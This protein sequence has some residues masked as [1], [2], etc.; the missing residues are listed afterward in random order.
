MSRAHPHGIVVCA[1]LPDAHKI[2]LTLTQ[3]L[4]N[5][6]TQ[7][8]TLTV[9]GAIFDKSLLF[10]NRF[11]DFTAAPT[12]AIL[13]DFLTSLIEPP[14][15]LFL[16]L[17]VPSHNNELVVPLLDCFAMAANLSLLITSSHKPLCFHCERSVLIYWRCEMC[18]GGRF[19]LCTECKTLGRGCHNAQHRLFE[20][21]NDQTMIDIDPLY[22]LDHRK[23][24][25]SR[26]MSSKIAEI[27]G[28]N[29]ED[30]MQQSPLIDEAFEG[31]MSHTIKD[32]ASEDLAM[33]A[34]LSLIHI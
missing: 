11:R 30:D 34:F 19:K 16:L 28:K 10:Y 33:P 1:F 31:I 7:I 6:I 2:T 25:L 22:S 15:R 26:A 13:M 27:Q 29:P 3:I 9:L 20:S 32:S 14:F 12:P 18:S 24:S 4:A 21:W 5:L 8:I 23:R 17:D